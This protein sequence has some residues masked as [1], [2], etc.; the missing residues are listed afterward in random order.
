MRSKQYGDMLSKAFSK[1]GTVNLHVIESES[2]EDEE[3]GESDKNYSKKRRE[4]QIIN[5]TSEDKVSPTSKSE[6]GESLNLGN[7]EGRFGWQ[8][9]SQQ[10]IE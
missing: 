2:E 9:I 8:A 4:I 3:S 1:W 5:N 10:S 7:G 6:G